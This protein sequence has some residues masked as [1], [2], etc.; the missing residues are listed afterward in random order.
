M[1]AKKRGL[2]RGL[3]ALLGSHVTET[4]NVDTSKV[5]RRELRDVPVDLGRGA[6]DDEKASARRLGRGKYGSRRFRILCGGTAVVFLRKATDC[7]VHKGNG[8]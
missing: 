1:A 6:C 5:D 2:G 3:D 8:V 7:E 4:M